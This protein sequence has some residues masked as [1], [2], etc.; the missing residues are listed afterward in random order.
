MS[1]AA[2]AFTSGSTALIT[3][4]ASGIGLA[5]AKLCHRKGMN[6]LLVDR[7]SDALEQARVDISGEGVDAAGPRVVTSV[8]DVSLVEDWVALKD[9]ALA[10][11][12]SIEFLV[13]NAGV[14]GKGTWG[15]SEYFRKVLWDTTWEPLNALANSNPDLGDE[16]VWRHQRR[17]YIPAHRARSFQNEAYRRHNYWQ[18]ARHHKP[19]WK[20][21]I[22]CV[23]I[24]SQDAS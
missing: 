18:Q 21:R 1:G 7:N 22:Q 11:F 12:G 24:C 6:V 13:L 8:A 9:S 17:E 16:F 19:A 14:G 5:V 10:K 20:R 2:A 23:Q 3:G 15:D 4:G